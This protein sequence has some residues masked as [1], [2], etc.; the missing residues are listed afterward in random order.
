VKNKLISILL[1]T[2]IA[3]PAKMFSELPQ[4]GRNASSLQV[5]S[6]AE[7]P[8]ASDALA[9]VLALPSATPR[10]PQDLL[11]DYEEGMAF[12]TQQFSGKVA[13]IAGAVQRG[14]LSREQGEDISAEQYQ[15]AQ[16]QFDLLSALREMLDQD[17]ARAAVAPQP[18]PKQEKESEIVMVALPFSSLQLNHSVIEYLDLSSAQVSSIQEVMSEERRTL[19]PL[20][21]Q[22][23]TTREQL[24]AVSEQG[25]NKNDKEVKTLAAL[26][27]RNLTKLIVANSRMRARIYQLLSPQQQKRLD[28]FQKSTRASL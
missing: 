8:A 1:W 9:D 17:L 22:L 6:N 3:V 2:V 10:G 25:Q 27:A 19:Q 16:M 14:E 21:A 15:M 18:N 5:G 23:Q 24:L 11:Q 26:Q 20:M 4:S 7:A 13:A 12:I 28:E